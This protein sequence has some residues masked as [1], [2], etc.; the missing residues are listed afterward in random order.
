MTIVVTEHPQTKM[1]SI[2]TATRNT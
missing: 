2:E 1:Q